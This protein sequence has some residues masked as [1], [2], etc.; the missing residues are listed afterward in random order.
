LALAR[1]GF[2]T[3]DLG[4]VFLRRA[5]QSVDHKRW[6]LFQLERLSIHA[7]DLHLIVSAE[8]G[9]LP[10]AILAASS[11]SA[12]Q[13]TTTSALNRSQRVPPGCSSASA[14]IPG[15]AAGVSAMVGSRSRTRDSRPDHGSCEPA[16]RRRR[17]RVGT[18]SAAPR[19]HRVARRQAPNCKGPLLGARLRRPRRAH[20]PTCT[21]RAQSRA[22]SRRSSRVA[23][24][25][26]SAGSRRRARSRPDADPVAGRKGCSRQLSSGTA[27]PLRWS[28]SGW[29]DPGAI[30]GRTSVAG[31][32]LA[33]P[34]E[35][36]NR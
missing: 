19:S 14:R 30:S 13:C 29:R 27:R 9:G 10:S 7:G 3:L 4:I 5:L 22:D 28:T 11:G 20:R 25:R 2:P 17:S 8:D 24:A 36:F 26:V 35:L 21:I 18:R 1:F 12:E 32:N 31:D 34:Y 16:R 23:W 6:A 33:P 15:R